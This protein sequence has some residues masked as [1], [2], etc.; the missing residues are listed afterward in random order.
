MDELKTEFSEMDHS[1]RPRSFSDF[2]GQKKLIQNLR[3]Y[4][5]AA[6][7]R[8]EPLDHL[9]LYGPPGLGKT[10]ISNMIAGEMGVNI[11]ITS[12]P[13]LEKK[14]DLAALLSNLQPGDV[15]FIDEIHRMNRAVEECLYPVLEDFKIDIVI[16]EGPHANI[17][18]IDINPFTLVG[19][20]TRLGL[21]T[22]PLRDRFGIISRL[23]YYTHEELVHILKRNSALLKMDITDEGAYEIAR[24]SRGTPRISNNILRR[25]RDIAQ[26]KQAPSITEDIAL[27]GLDHLDIDRNGLD[28]MSRKLLQVLHE[29]FQGGPVGLS[30]LAIALSEET[31]T[32]EDVYEPFLINR[33][34]LE[35]TPRGRVMT[36]SARELFG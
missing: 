20:T 4:I 5:E 34:F 11:K 30:T 22:S 32:I 25:V 36:Q 9:L 1:L 6:K 12:G 2:T 33:G 21:L 27:L 7:T 13:I 31:N 15:L 26:V 29:K 10:T 16:G 24:C 14:A 19:A 3:I 23:E 28:Y 8:K 35:R 17:I 18:R